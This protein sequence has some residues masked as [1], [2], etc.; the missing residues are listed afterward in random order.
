MTLRDL[1]EIRILRKKYNLNQKE[2]A[3]SAGV[4]QSLIAKIEAG[5]VDPTYTKAKK[6]FDSLE[7][8]RQREE[9]KAEEI[10]SKQIKFV[11]VSDPLKEVVRVMKETGI[12]QVPVTS[13]GKVCGIITESIIL[14]KVLSQPESAKV[15][16]VGDIMD[17]APPIVS[18]KTGFRV[19]S[20]LLK[21][22]SILLV[23]EKGEIRG[24]I[25][26]ADLLE[27]I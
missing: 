25:S 6:I 10:M 22:Y 3:N 15:V 2:L 13:R 26:K 21:D 12:S 16:K 18:P 5:K 7:T 20:E 27:R 11:Q 9:L 17:E 19:L 4:S 8:L 1:K 14:K 24:V 23:A